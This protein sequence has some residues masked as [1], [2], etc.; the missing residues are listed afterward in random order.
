MYYFYHCMKKRLTFILVLLQLVFVATA[1]KQ[2][3]VWYFG[4]Y[5]G[6]DFNTGQPQVL[7]GMFRSIRSCA[8]M[9]DP[10][11]N[12]LFAT[13]GETIWNRNKTIMQNGTGL[14]GS[15][16][17]AQGALIIQKPGSAN[18]YYVFTTPSINSPPGLYYS[19]VNMKLNDGLGAVTAEKN[20][21]LYAAWDAVGKIMAVRYTNG[22]DIWVIA[23]KYKEES[24]YS[25]FLVTSNGIDP[26][27]VI[28][29]S[30]ER[31]YLYLYIGSVKIT[32]EK[33]YLI[34]GFGWGHPGTDP[35]ARFDV[36]RFNASTG[37]IIFMYSVRIKEDNSNANQTPNSV[38]FSPDSKLA[39][40]CTWAYATGSNETTEHR[41]Y[42]YDMSLIEDSAQFV[43]S[44]LLITHDGGS[45]LQLA[46]DGKIYCGIHEYTSETTYSPVSVIH[47]PWLR[48]T[49]C[50]FEEDA[51]EFPDGH[52]AI[53]YFPNILLDYL[54]R[55][56]FDG[57]CSA[58]PFY[59]QSNFQPVPAFIEW[60]F[61]DPLSG[62][63]NISHDI[64][65]V[66]TF[67]GGGQYEV[68]AHVE[69]PNGRIEETSRVVTVTGTPKPNLG[70]DILKCENEE[71]TLNAG[72]EQGFYTWSTGVLGENANEITVSDTG[73]YWVQVNNDGC[74]GYDTVHVG[75]YPKPEVNEDSLHIIPTACG[76]STG[77][78]LGLEVT[79]EEP[80]SFQW[81]DADSNYLT[82]TLDLTGL[83]V[84]NY[85]LH[86]LDGNGC[87]TITHAYTIE[88]AGDIDITAVE[89][90]DARCGQ[91]NGSITVTAGSGS[92]EDLLYSVDNGNTWQ[93]ANG[94]FENLQAGNYFVRVKD[95]LGCESVYE[96]NPVV[97]ENISGP[98]V[99]SVTTVPE[100]DYLANGEINITATVDTGQVFYSIDNGT[101]FQTDNGK[102]T[103]LTAGTYSCVVKDNYGC[104]TTFTVELERTISQL[105]EAIAGDGNTCI[106]NAA[107]VPLKLSN[108]TDIYKFHVTLTYDT[109][110]LSCEGYL[111]VHPKLKANL[112][113][114]IIPG[115]NEVIITW[116][117]DTATTLEDNATMLE[118]V[119]G[120]KKEGLSGIDWAAQAGQSAFYNGQLDQVN[121]EYH[122]GTLR[123]YTRPEIIM[124][125]KQDK[126]EGETFTGFPFV[127]GGSGEITYEW[128]GPDNFF[129]TKDIVAIDNLTQQNA[130]IY[131]LTVTDTIDCV[132]KQELDLTV[133][134]NPQVA[135]AGQDT[136]F[137]QPGFALKAGSGY[138]GY[139]WNTGD[140][141]DA[142]Q[143]NSEGQYWVIVTSTESCQAADTV[144]VL[145]GGEPFW[146]PNAFTPNG[147]GLNDEFK[148]VQRY[149]FVKT[150]R[151]F[152]YNRWGQLIFDTPD[153]NQGWDGTF[154]GQPA[155]QG[156]YVY[157]IVYTA[158]PTG[159]E[160]RT[161]TGNVMLV[162]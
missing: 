76:G 82:N 66:H 11:G 46:T 106:G 27:P 150:Y 136:I 119:F 14:K 65:P 130:G 42:Q 49:A 116:Q 109:A 53:E 148:P 5:A 133:N 10:T 73:W 157:K 63:N 9:S 20:V 117:G 38:E 115:G 103:N 118:L 112:Q 67:T 34:N 159:R 89:K 100:I 158:Y 110:M 47:Y 161:K 69:Y 18:L 13:N 142:I 104:D 91:N 95:L 26:T 152:I 121:A 62:S 96:N 81:Y 36:N 83:A 8:S 149:D 131:T 45:G 124:E 146:L 97:I 138:A 122:T 88:D 154:K 43:Q 24:A 125:N 120:A 143:V 80:L 77:K 30:P 51:I 7:N 78:I 57:H 25:A 111:K 72:N 28:S 16:G 114:S 102:F 140:T 93:T 6:L 156:T 139:L 64:N 33:K 22:Q 145:W 35:Y 99:T 147:D 29:Y 55:F 128:T 39:Y 92:T 108:F 59:F 3:N 155:E 144:M 135:F 84:G 50:F 151:L 48:G 17:N 75:M 2:A 54:Y 153:I 86:I 137:A 32:H 113:V 101:A 70:P 68:H 123:V 94:S 60:N 37:E 79:G 1:Q 52:G 15:E 12:F 41:L 31:P 58:D 90:E 162:R 129:S 132:T 107:V 105:I 56:G 127:T 141:T 23:R 87:T 98:Q 44:A 160:T 40:L 134:E 126:C 19:V 85:F 4:S 71:V 61:A 74:P 21:L